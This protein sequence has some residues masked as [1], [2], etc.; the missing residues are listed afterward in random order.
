MKMV[1]IRHAESTANLEGVLAG[2]TPGVKLTSNGIKQ[3]EALSELFMKIN[4]T[5]IYSSPIER[6]MT[7]AKLAMGSRHEKVQISEDF[8]E[9]DYGDWTG[10]KIDSLSTDPLW[11][12]IRNEPSKAAFPEG[13]SLHQMGQRAINGFKS[14][15]DMHSASD[16]VAI[17][18]HADII[19]AIVSSIVGN[20][21]DNYQRFQVDNAKLNILTK[22]DQVF[23]LWGLN[24]SIPGGIEYLQKVK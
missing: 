4:F 2:R 7:T 11:P 5:A 1:L 12:V 17:F 22:S 23:D 3:A 14:I 16:I 13:E 20:H 18:S 21:F 8:T 19:K 9:V 10:R 6:C 24:Q 15:I